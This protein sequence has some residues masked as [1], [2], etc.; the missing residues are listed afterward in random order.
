[1]VSSLEPVR[2]IKLLQRF[3]FAVQE[4]LMFALVVMRSH[5]DR[6][7]RVAKLPASNP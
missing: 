2:N 4:T 6:L 1:M 5:A 3:L 7:D